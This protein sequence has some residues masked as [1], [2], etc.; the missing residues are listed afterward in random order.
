VRVVLD[1]NTLVSG[2]FWGR[3]P[4][5]ILENWISD[6][7]ELIISEEIL[8]E[9]ERVLLRISKGKRD[10]IISRWLLLITGNYY[11][12]N[13]K[14]KYHLS[15]D[16]DDDKFIECAVS[17][18]AQYIVSGDSHLIGLKSVMNITILSAA[19]FLKMI[20]KAK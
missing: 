11:I 3:I 12:I 2:V 18:N 14:K 15:S 4:Y 13:V 8:K 7:F 19:E 5:K 20:E 1:T 9:Y 17:G 10:Q 16:P 6:R